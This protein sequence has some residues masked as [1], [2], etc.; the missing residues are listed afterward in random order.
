MTINREM[1]HCQTTEF[2]SVSRLRPLPTEE[3]RLARECSIVALFCGIVTLVCSGLAWMT[4]SSSAEWTEPRFFVPLIIG[5]GSLSGSLSHFF[6][7]RR[8]RKRIISARELE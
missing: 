1:K 8:L 4:Y 5:I 2:L 3:E 7:G 6:L